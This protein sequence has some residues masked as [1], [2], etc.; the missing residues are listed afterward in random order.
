SASS[1]PNRSDC[2]PGPKLSGCSQATAASP[3]SVHWTA[4]AAGVI[5]D[6]MKAPE[7]DGVQDFSALARLRDKLRKLY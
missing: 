7:R 5:A 3:C 2:V 4:V 1:R 6:V